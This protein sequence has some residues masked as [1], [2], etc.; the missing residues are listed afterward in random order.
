MELG[1]TPDK[2]KG[3]ESKTETDALPG[4]HQYTEVVELS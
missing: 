2:D 4:H 1:A 3:G